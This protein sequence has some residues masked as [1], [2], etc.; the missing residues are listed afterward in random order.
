MTLAR[1]LTAAALT[2]PLLT[3]AAPAV[4]EPAPAR[5]AVDLPVVQA[6]ETL[7]LEKENRAGYKRTKFKHWVDADKDGCN[8][9]QEVLIEEATQ[10]PEVG[11]RC[12]LTGGQ[13][14]SY[15]DAKTTD[16]PRSLD[17]DHMVPLA[18]AWD[19][20]ASQ[21]DAK[22]RERYANDLG[23]A[24]SLVA[25]TARENRQKADRDPADWWV[26]AASAS[27]RY[28]SDWVATKVRWHLALDQAEKN[29]LGE[30]AAAC[31]NT[32]VKTDIAH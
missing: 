31:P 7:P 15:Y 23:S 14:L 9:R 26:P 32:R 24:R 29:A 17:I 16:N 3:A 10:E 18:E 2:L 22:K 12:S 25:V 5:Q 4:A 30:R 13:W 20:G 6:I 19:S 21:W 11:P 27:C 8:T 28:L 1:G